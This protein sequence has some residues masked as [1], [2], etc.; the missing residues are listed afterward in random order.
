MEGLQCC[1]AT[2]RVCGM[3]YDPG[4]APERGFKRDPSWQSGSSSD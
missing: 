1:R 4:L 2:L 3:A